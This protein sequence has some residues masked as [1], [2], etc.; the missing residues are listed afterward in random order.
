MPYASTEWFRKARWGAFCHYLGKP[1]MTAEAWND[2]VDAFDVPGL[3]EQLK[4]V[5][6]PYFFLTIGQNSGHYCSP[7]AAYDR[8]V[9]IRPS[10][11]SRRDLVMD[12]AN[13]LTAA[14]IRLMVYLPSGAPDKDPVAIEKLKWGSPTTGER[15]DEFQRHWE[16]IIREWSERWGRK[17]HG[18][19]IDGCYFAKD[20]YNFPDEPNFASFAAALKAGNPDAIVAF[21]PGVKTPVIS[22]TEHEDY[23]A[24]EIA[25]DLPV[26]EWY[27]KEGFDP[28]R[29]EVNGAQYHILSFLGSMWCAG[30]PRFPIELVIGYTRFITENGGVVT[31]DVPIE[32]GGRIPQ[33]FMDQLA[34]LSRAMR[35]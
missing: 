35:A 9:D 21:N 10:K 15:L 26:G 34:A 3:V 23:T 17:V 11:C 16:A 32:P 19:W 33:P 31:W 13:A 27:P 2:Q 8:L 12:L 29:G 14:G 24:G 25:G 1:E 6:A 7:N 4:S 22:M 18:W 20:M 5:A 30:P 28:I